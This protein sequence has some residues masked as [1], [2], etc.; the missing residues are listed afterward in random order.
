MPHAIWILWRLWKSRNTLLFQAKQ[1]P[2][3]TTM[4]LAE[5]DAKEWLDIHQHHFWTRPKNSWIKCNY[6]GSYV[7]EVRK[8]RAAQSPLKSGVQVLIMAMQFCWAKGYMK[9]S[10]EGDCKNLVSLLNKESL[11]FGCHYW[12]RETWEWKKRFENIE[13][14]WM[15]RENN[16]AADLLSTS[17]T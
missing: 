5:N 13:F 9:V 6:D 11:N 14:I 15:Y 2:W 10:F 12:I 7:K 8:N 4:K 1:I 16:Q 3:R 17:T